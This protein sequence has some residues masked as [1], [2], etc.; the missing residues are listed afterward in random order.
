M[1]HQT[2]GSELFLRMSAEEYKRVLSIIARQGGRS[3]SPAKQKASSANL[4]KARAVRM[5]NLGK[6]VSNG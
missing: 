5:A 1:E 4:K 6:V 2:K 3:R